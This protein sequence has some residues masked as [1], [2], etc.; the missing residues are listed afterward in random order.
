MKKLICLLSLLSTSVLAHESQKDIQV[1]V[2]TKGSLSWDG[3]TLPHYPSG[4]PEISILKITIAPNTRLPLHQHG[5]INAG[6]LLKGELTV[7]TEK[8]ETLQLKTGDPIVE[9]IGKWHYGVNQG[10]SPAEIMVFYAGIQGMANTITQDTG[11]E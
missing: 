10:N 3:Q 6:V 4:Q 9:V 7:I 1:E 2:L 11:S 8:G 5:V